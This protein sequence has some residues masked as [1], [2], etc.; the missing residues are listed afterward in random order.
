MHLAGCR[1]LPGVHIGDNI[2]AYPDL[3]VKPCG[4]L[5]LLV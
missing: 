4:R 1:Y 5:A 3:K 2:T